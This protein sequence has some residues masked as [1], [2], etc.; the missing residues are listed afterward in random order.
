MYG[1][2]MDATTTL[3][4]AGASGSCGRF[5]LLL[6]VRC[7]HEQGD[8]S[9]IGCPFHIPSQT[10]CSGLWEHVSR[11]FNETWLLSV[12]RQF[13]IGGPIFQG[14]NSVWPDLKV[15]KNVCAPIAQQR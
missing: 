11:T 12:A 13:E 2:A 15:C 5:L 14:H 8:K 7:L 4:V 6:E 9:R 3:S 1:N 10:L